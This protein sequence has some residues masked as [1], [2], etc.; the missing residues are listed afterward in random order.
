MQCT[1]PSN[2]DGN[3]CWALEASHANGNIDFFNTRTDADIATLRD[4]PRFR[5]IL[6][7]YQKK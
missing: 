7:K 6:E 3:P 1:L 4:D 2:P 5:A